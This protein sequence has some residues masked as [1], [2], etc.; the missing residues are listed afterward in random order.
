MRL[1][2]A[3]VLA[4]PVILKRVIH[5]KA[6]ELVD[7][8]ADLVHRQYILEKLEEAEAYASRPDAKWYT[9][10]EF[11]RKIKEKHGI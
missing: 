2:V 6:I 7:N 10:K 1:T 9:E 3:N 11:W 4:K 8:Q 5:N